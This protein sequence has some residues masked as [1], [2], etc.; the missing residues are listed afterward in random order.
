MFPTLIEAMT[1]WSYTLRHGHMPALNNSG[2]Q[3]EPEP[4][5]IWD[6]G[7]VRSLLTDAEPYVAAEKLLAAIAETRGY[8]SRAFKRWTLDGWTGT[9]RA[10]GGGFWGSIGWHGDSGRTGGTRKV[11]MWLTNGKSYQF[12]CEGREATNEPQLIALLNEFWR[13]IK[14]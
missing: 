1:L 7:A 2:R 11:G 5:P 4:A 14:I 8:S 10:Y 13:A 9:E 3:D 12:D 6:T